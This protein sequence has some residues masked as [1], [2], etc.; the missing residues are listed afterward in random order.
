MTVVLGDCLSHDFKFH[1]LMLIDV[2]AD[3]DTKPFLVYI[4]IFCLCHL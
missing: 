3:V 2:Q 1:L 4:F